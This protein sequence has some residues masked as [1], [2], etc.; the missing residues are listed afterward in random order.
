[1]TSNSLPRIVAALAASI[2]IHPGPVAAAPGDLDPG[3]GTGGKVITTF[4]TKGGE[5]HGVVIQSDGKVVVAGVAEYGNTRNFALARYLSDGSLDPSFGEGGKVTTSWGSSDSGRGVA[6]QTDGKI[7]VAGSVSSWQGSFFGLARYLANGAVDTSFGNNGLATTDFGEANDDAYSV[8]VQAD[9]K[10]VVAGVCSVGGRERMGLVRYNVDGTLDASFGQGGKVIPMVGGYSDQGRSVVIQTDGKIIV[11]G[12]SDD[13]QTQDYFALVRLLPNGAPDTGF[14]IGGKVVTEI[15]STL[16]NQ[17]HSL[18]L[19]SDGKIVLA[20]FTWVNAHDFAVARYNP[21][22]TLDSGFGNAGKVITDIGDAFGSAAAVQSD[23]K[24]VVTGWTESGGT[25]VVAVVRYQADGDLDS[26][27][28]D[29]G[30]VTTAV[31]NASQWGAYGSAVAVQN[32]GKIVVAGAAHNGSYFECAVVRYIG[33][34]EPEIAVEQP[35]GTNLSDG[36]ANIDFGSVETAGGSAVRTFTVK[37]ASTANL[38]G[39]VVSRDGV[40]GGEFI[41]T[42][43]G[44]SILGPGASTTFAVT[45]A[46][47][48]P[49][50]RTATLHVAS[51]DADEN[52]FDISL[53]GTGMGLAKPGALDLGFG[54]A[55]RVITSMAGSRGRASGMA[56][57]NDGKI[58]VAGAFSS[59]NN[60]DFALLRYQ[61]DGTL[62]GSFGT[63]G[64]VT[65]P[66]G[67]LQDYG[68]SVVVQGD[69]K[70]VVA[71]DSFNGTNSDFALVRYEAD[72]RLDASFGNGGKVI[73]GI[74][75]NSGEIG[76]SVA[77]QR[78]GKILIA[79][80]TDNGTVNQDIALVRY[81]ANGALD[82][83]FGNGGKVTTDISGKDDYGT[84]AAV[85]SDG[86]IL[87]AGYSD[88]NDGTTD[89]LL[90]RYLADG[91][92]DTSF[93]N[94]GK[95]V[96][97]VGPY[98]GSAQWA[99]LQGDG[100]IL[101]TG[102]TSKGSIDD[103]DF[104]LVRYLSNGTLDTAFGN[105]GKVVTDLADGSDDSAQSVALQSDGRIVVAGS[106]NNGG[107]YDFA[108]VRYNADGTLDSTFGYAGKILTPI[109]ASDDFAWS[110]A[111]QNDG[112][113]VIAGDTRN[114]SSYDFALVRY[115]GATE[116]E[117]AVEQPA[118][119]NLVD[120]SA[121]VD[122]GALALDG[123]PASL[124]FTVKNP[125]SA[126]LKNLA[127]RLDGANAGDFTL[128]ALGA[129]I[130]GMGESTT[131]TVRCLPA[132]AG[133]RSAV[134]RI[135]SDD[136]D[137]NPFDI[138][139]TAAGLVGPTITT[140]SP[141]PSGMVGVPYSL[142]FTAGGGAQPY[143]WSAAPATL[144]PGLALSTQGVL[145]GT[146]TTVIN[147]RFTVLV[148]G[149]DSIASVKEFTL[150][151]TP[152]INPGDLD[153]SFGTGGRVMTDIG[154]GDDFGY[155][156]LVQPDGKIVV[157][158]YSRIG[159]SEDFAVVR[160]L[161]DGSLDTGFGNGGKVTTAVGLTADFGRSVALQKD[162]KILVAG[163]YWN[164]GGNNFAL[165][166]YL[167]NG[168]VDTVFGTA[169]K[170]T[171]AFG[172]SSY[173]RGV[174]VQSDGKIVLAGEVHD[175]GV[176]FGLVRYLPDGS[177]DTT[178][179]TGGKVITD[180][181]NA[182]YFDYAQGATLQPDDKILVAGYVPGAS[183]N[184][185]AL[186]R[187]LPNGAL[188]TAF[189][190]AGKVTT[191]I[192]TLHDLG[193]TV[194][195]QSDGK[196]VVA[197]EVAGDFAIVRYLTDG[198]LDTGFG[199]GGKVT[200]AIGRYDDFPRSIALD[201]DGKIVVAGY[202][203]NG[204]NNDFALARYLP[205]GAL[206]TT[207]GTGGKVMTAVGPGHDY[208]RSVL[209]QR[210]GRI[211]VAG[212][213]FNGTNNDFAL[214][215]YNGSPAPDL[216]PIEEWRLAH[217]GSPD[218]IGDGADR[219]DFDK[220]GFINIAEY[221]FGGDPKVA[222]GADMRLAARFTA[223]RFSLSFK[224]DARCTDIIYTVQAASSP[225]AA[226]W[227][228]IA[229]SAG[230]ATLLPIGT[231][232]EAADP[233][234][235]LRT[236]TLT[237]SPSLF[238]T[239]GGY[240]RIRISD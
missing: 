187:Y 141:L 17:G 22:G 77:L 2:L 219:N 192:G 122:F 225:D 33:T 204:S 134:L 211:V 96:T 113:I 129:V 216:T 70:I 157:A 164:G 111:V 224:C 9:G 162:G 239:S 139:L 144:P 127:L 215:R 84:S 179:G 166:R 132:A 104:A 60:Y 38:V 76:R 143:S 66:L 40:N 32:D 212:S 48:G 220:D 74:R 233:G 137:E 59:G 128:G 149:S 177:L 16:D 188:D 21:N 10:L 214:V 92:L 51:N 61:K 124:T 115:H 107:N 87:V 50:L 36:A 109:G 208:G 135:S 174:L 222:D 52:P 183:G 108:V 165:V 196:I 189:G 63:Q 161:P 140:P 231:L 235:G 83:T 45:F 98:Y 217:F 106:S 4:G 229:Q 147:A 148:R 207:F 240:L 112:K 176:D 167:A 198:S 8:A 160:Y 184:D 24:I 89:F 209:V 88:T 205:N 25:G 150:A 199:N 85:Q 163:E 19:Q 6:L 57:Q 93:G 102:S 146:P 15:G 54:Q 194:A 118:G 53:S 119:N 159:N 75:N 101:V 126:F 136:A 171:N 158:G 153:T 110:V 236:V 81:G 178:F 213:A 41:V 100:K 138:T 232:C 64:M 185:F 206:D 130:L 152:F 12:S 227:T 131:F 34:T 114:G 200:T 133:P 120:G 228:D 28:A 68:R 62:D 80:Y 78:D 47:S 125:S 31:N 155:G 173:A 42:Q 99:I 142:T 37:N 105:G 72:G 151:F 71:G 193:R 82:P 197:G 234:T 65:T 181:G 13:T 203:G 44:T 69:G 182:P 49:G 237:A 175:A 26:S 35:A 95:V 79:G 201:R 172:S 238:Q 1:M 29:G 39:L 168:A 121:A 18:L 7:V 154:T 186:A 94:G 97:A 23:G 55:G 90:M 103:F 3:F 20:G 218:N 11:G 86:K 14:G 46:P 223:D 145:S 67:T 117:I 210:N 180:F 190:T 169:G 73:T 191:P 221:A 91:T 58:L 5:G 30:K 27:F 170:V 123:G 116:P 202:S 230:G 226:A 195:V 56:L 156:A 43:P